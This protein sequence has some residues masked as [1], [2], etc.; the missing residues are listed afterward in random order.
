MPE[1]INDLKETAKN[2]MPLIRVAQQLEERDRA[3]EEATRDL[4]LRAEQADA[5]KVEAERLAAQ[6]KSATE[7]HATALRAQQDAFKLLEAELET[8]RKARDES[9]GRLQEQLD[10]ISS[11]ALGTRILPW[12]VDLPGY[13]VA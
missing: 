9:V 2:S 10:L 6:L 4:R 11:A 12:P 1:E 8:T 7:G 5:H 3:H 13:F